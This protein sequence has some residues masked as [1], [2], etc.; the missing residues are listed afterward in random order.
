V[1]EN[2]YGLR[3]PGLVI[4]PY[5]RRGAIDRHVRSFDSYLKFIEDVFLGG[6]R[7][8]PRTDGRPDSRPTVRDGMSLIGSLAADFDFNQRPRRPCVLPET[9]KRPVACHD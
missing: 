6:A 5:A 1:D 4:S 7:I 3:V 8:D 9:P 2:G